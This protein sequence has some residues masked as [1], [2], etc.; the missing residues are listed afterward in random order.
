MTSPAKLLRPNT[1]L[2]TGQNDLYCPPSSKAKSSVLPTTGSGETKKI[3][4]LR[5]LLK[6]LVR[7]EAG[8]PEVVE[9]YARLSALARSQGKTMGQNDL[10][11][12]ATAQAVNA[13][14]LTSDQDFLWL[15][16]E[17]IQLILV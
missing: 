5:L 6:N 2:P 13:L 7:V 9:C 1:L 12:A 14:L 4:R 17:Y 16:P 10:W 8:L 3:Q 11:I 15:S